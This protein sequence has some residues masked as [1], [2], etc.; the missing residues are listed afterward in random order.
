MR[1]IYILLWRMTGMK[2][3]KSLRNKVSPRNLATI[4]Q[5]NKKEKTQTQKDVER[6]MSDLSK[7]RKRLQ[8][9]PHDMESRKEAGDF[10][11][12]CD[13]LMMRPELLKDTSTY[14]KV[15][16]IRDS[17]HSYIDHYDEIAEYQ[18]KSDEYRQKLH[19]QQEKE[20]EMALRMQKSMEDTKKKGS[21]KDGQ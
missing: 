21:K 8:R 19:E 2:G 13:E 11:I 3:W 7:V 18:D 14:D 1:K 17:M 10:V 4:R 9:N 15:S 16:R 12:R 6:L 20:R 5:A